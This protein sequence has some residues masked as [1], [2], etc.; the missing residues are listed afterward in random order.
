MYAID[1][2]GI[3]VI[4]ELPTVAHTKAMSK[5]AQDQLYIF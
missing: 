4:K 5:N 3:L 1:L 2:L